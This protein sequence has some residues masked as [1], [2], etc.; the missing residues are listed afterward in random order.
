MPEIEDIYVVLLLFLLYKDYFN[1]SKETDSWWGYND[2]SKAG[3]IF[4]SETISWDFS[5][6]KAISTCYVLD[7]V[8]SV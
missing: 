4:I 2:N 6:I 1:N 3:K 8:C 5:F 7:P